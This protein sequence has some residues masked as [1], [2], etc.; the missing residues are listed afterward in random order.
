MMAP[1][2]AYTKPDSNGARGCLLGLAVGDVLGCP[3]EAMSPDRIRE[4]Y[5]RLDDLVE[6]PVKDLSDTYFW[7]LPG[8]HSDDTQQALAITDILVEYGEIHE[9]A[10][11]DLWKEM[12][13]AYIVVRSARTGKLKQFKEGFGSHRGTGREFR[14]RIRAI[15]SPPPA[16][17]GDGAAMRVAPIGVRF[18]DDRM[19]RIDNAVRS[20]LATSSHPHAA[21]SAAAIAAATALSLNRKPVAPEEFIAG[22]ADETRIAEE[23]LKNHYF[24]R[25]DPESK[26]AINELSHVLGELAIWYKLPLQDALDRIARNAE[27][28]LGLDGL[29]ATKSFALT[30]IPTSILVAARHLDDFREGVIE[31]INL[32]GDTDTI[33]AMVG[34]ILGARNGI[35]SI[36]GMWREKVI[37]RDQI[38]MWGQALLTGK[39]DPDWVSL[40]DLEKKLTIKEARERSRIRAELLGSRKM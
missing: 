20:A 6:T 19:T 24:D 34:G 3:V 29:F 21:A 5:G 32:G 2:K 15:A 27:K 10:L 35:E 25:I 9:K 37:A 26:K 8:L 16:S 36:P 30:A 33:G 22:V 11:L 38:L 23:H 7:R 1:E 13:E 4:K 31:A 14:N 28:R 18:F 17:N 12:A 39:K 40:Y